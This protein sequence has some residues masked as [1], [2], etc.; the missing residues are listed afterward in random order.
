MTRV[1]QTS[2]GRPVEAA[3]SVK[4]DLLLA[5][6]RLLSSSGREGA[7]ARAICSEAQV[8][9]PAMYHHYGDLQGMHQAA[10]DETFR[11]ISL[12]YRR[13]TIAKGP[14]QGIRNGWMMFMKFANEEPRLCRIVIEQML[15]G[16]PPRAVASTLKKIERDMESM[17][18]QGTLNGRADEAVQLLW[19]AALGAACLASIESGD[20]GP[21]QRL[22]QNQATQQRMLE[23]ILASLA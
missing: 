4:K 12:A 7:T 16:K 10:V 22:S 14:L 5:A 2:S 1:K 19:S 8:G 20:A 6:I 21:G 3:R 23:A 18:E 17:K 15:A 13:G 11:I 9:A